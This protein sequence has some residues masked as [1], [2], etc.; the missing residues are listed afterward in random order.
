M[1][2]DTHAHL[3][4]ERFDGDVE[5]VLRRAWEAG[6]ASIVCVG[7]DL[8]SSRAAV[9]FAREHARVFAA[10]GIHPNAVDQADQDAWDE[11]CRL[12][13]AEAVVGI[14][15]TGLDNF[16]KR[17][18]P[19]LQAEWLRRHLELAAE[20]DKPVII[21][22]RDASDRVGQMLTEWLDD[23]G[24]TPWR[25]VLH[26]FSGDEPLMRELAARQ[27][28]ISIAGP[29]TFRN[30]GRL[31]EVATAVPPDRLVLETDCPYLSPVPRRGQRNEPANV[32]LT[33]T[34][35]AELRGISLGALAEQTTR[36]ACAL[37]RLPT[38]TGGAAS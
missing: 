8:P 26:C 2:V 21:H 35:V 10:V 14:G 31:V 4:D 3:Q 17:T 24:A 28:A 7:Y 37:F 1:L 13:R 34:K 22:N 27:I 20:L 33:A 16:R 36:N 25:G 23:V 5:A 29:V 30:A 6:L 9:R 38:Q 19:A 32:A 18:P 12:A 11:I 15:E